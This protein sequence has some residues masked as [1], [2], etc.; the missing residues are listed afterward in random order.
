MRE[1]HQTPVGIRDAA[2]YLPGPAIDLR[3]WAVEQDVPPHHVTQL[4]ENGCRYFHEGPDHADADLIASA[5]DRMLARDAAWL[6]DVRYLIHTHTQ[7][8]S[9]PAPPSSILSDLVARYRLHPALCF[10]IGHMACAGAIN[11]IAWAERLLHEDAAARYALVVT[12]DRVF[13]DARHRLRLPGTIQSD[14]ASAILVAKEG[15]R[16][17]LGRIDIFS[18]PDLHAGPSTRANKVAI[19]RQTWIHTKQLLLAHSEQAGMQLS[20]YPQILPVNADRHYWTQIAAGLKLPASHFFFDNIPLRGHAC[21]ADLAVNLVDRGF[22]LLDQGQ[23]VLLCGQ[24]N[25]GA[26]AAMTL[27]PAGAGPRQPARH[28]EAS[29]CA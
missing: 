24:S 15:V 20:D 25:I 26:H 17:I 4:E 6:P 27:L 12:S 16:C 8:F 28:E 2:Y 3:T 19:A 10:S 13:G 23:P 22:A 14:G 11:A 29:A 9:M 21:C 5:I 18:A 1:H 7:N